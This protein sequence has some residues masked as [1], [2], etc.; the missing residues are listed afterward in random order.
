MRALGNDEYEYE[1]KGVTGT[2]SLAQV[3]EEW[4]GEVTTDVLRFYAERVAEGRLRDAERT[5]ERARREAAE[6]A[7][8]RSVLFVKQLTP[9]A[10]QPSVLKQRSVLAGRRPNVLKQRS[11]LF[12]KQLSASK[13]KSVP[14]TPRVPQRTR[15]PTISM[16]FST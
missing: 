1:Y 16:Q 9:S 6:R 10:W 11:V 8:Q 5:E 7:Q 15:P 14:P 2:F 3:A 12:V 13:R 4:A